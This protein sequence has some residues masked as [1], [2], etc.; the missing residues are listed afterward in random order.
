M[1][2]TTSEHEPRFNAVFSNPRT[3]SHLLFKLLNLADQSSV[4]KHPDDGYIFMRPTMMRLKRGLGGKSVSEWTVHD[5]KSVQSMFQK[6]YDE[7]ERW[8]QDAQ[9]MGKGAYL[10]FHCL[11]LAEPVSE[12]R[13]LHGV[14]A[15]RG[16]QSW[17]VSPTGSASARGTRLRERKSE[18][19][20][21]CLPDATLKSWRPTF[22][23]RHP[24]LVLPSLLRADLEFGT[25]AL[26][27]PENEEDA[28]G[29]R[30]AWEAAKEWQVTFHWQRQLLEWFLVNLTAEE[31]YTDEDDVFFP[32]VLDADDLQSPSA[33]ELLTRYTRAVGL[34]PESVKFEWKTAPKE[35]VD[36]MNIYEKRLLDT[37]STSTGIV[38]GK[39]AQG[40]VLENETTKWRAEFG[41]RLGTK[42]GKWVKAAMSDYERMHSM[43]LTVDDDQV[44]RAP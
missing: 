2:S 9:A 36:E 15:A 19:N 8:R 18:G 5:K 28:S 25:D 37:I 34:D 42:L 43:R 24:A 14:D 11:E 41:E 31:M 3:A 10:K 4:R 1:S 22:L 23:I 40:L 17:T 6:S 7:L 38:P 16:M 27:S 44:V 39:T 33:P 13:W 20:E 21:T 26:F 30:R 29:Y 12:T 35:E 32:I